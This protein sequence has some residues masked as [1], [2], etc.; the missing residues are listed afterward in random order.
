M[1][2]TPR[3][4]SLVRLKKRVSSEPDSQNLPFINDMPLIYL[5]EITNMPEHGVFAGYKSGRIYSGF[6]IF[7]F[8]ELK[9]DEV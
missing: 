8:V 3:R 7:Q 9:D 5:G 4:L 1:S 6:H 2:K